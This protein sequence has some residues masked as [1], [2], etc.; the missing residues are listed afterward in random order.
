MCIVYSSP[1]SC[2]I[3][4]LKISTQMKVIIV[5]GIINTRWHRACKT[6]V[7]IILLEGNTYIN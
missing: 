7:P 2:Y 1:T 6:A 3:D 4:A 5:I